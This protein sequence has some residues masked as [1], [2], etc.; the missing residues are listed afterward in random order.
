[1]FSINQTQLRITNLKALKYQDTE[2]QYHSLEFMDLQQTLNFLSTIYLR[3]SRELLKEQYQLSFKLY[4][5]ILC[6][7]ILI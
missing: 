5:A 3:V 6:V 2:I 4:Q 1:M 7:E